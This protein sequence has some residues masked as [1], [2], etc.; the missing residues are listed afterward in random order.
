[1][2]LHISTSVNHFIFTIFA[3]A[4][5]SPIVT[6]FQ[7]A[8]MRRPVI[9]QRS[10][11]HHQRNVSAPRS[12]TPT[13]PRSFG[14]RAQTVHDLD[15]RPPTFTYFL[16]TH[17]K[18]AVA[19]RLDIAHQECSGCHRRMCDEIHAPQP[20]PVC[21]PRPPPL[22]PRNTGRIQCIPDR[23]P[24]KRRPN[25]PGVPRPLLP[26]NVCPDYAKCEVAVRISTPGCGHVL[27]SRCLAIWLAEGNEG[28]PVCRTVWFEKDGV[29]E[30]DGLEGLLSVMREA[31]PWRWVRLPVAGSKVPMRM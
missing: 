25:G 2:T 13:A 23:L 3:K 5:R 20:A 28:C 16:N 26:A 18:P 12:P 19:S 29:N 31:W 4:A 21:L 30:K 14:P 22:P 27:G 8:T 11:K 10:P 15:H 1:M 9:I 24:T 7:T 6:Y 17:I